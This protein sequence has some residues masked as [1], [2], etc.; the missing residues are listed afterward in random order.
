MEAGEVI[1]PGQPLGRLYDLSWLRA[2]VDVPDRYAPLIDTASPLVQRYIDLAMPGAVQDVTAAITI[3]GLPKLTGGTY[4]GIELPAEVH[5]VAH[6]ASPSS[7]TVRVELRLQ[8]PGGALKEGIIGQ[9]RITFLRY[10]RAIIIPLKAV[11][12]AEV[13][14]RV[15]VVEQSDGRWIARVRDIEPISI[16]DDEMLVRGGVTGGEHLVVSG[17]KGIVDGQEVL[18]VVADGHVVQAS[19][20]GAGDGPAASGR[21]NVSPGE[22]PR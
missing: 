4:A 17:A 3:P 5:R 18:V 22:A 7:N 13:G 14:P 11:Q 16:Q 2:A 21:N 1:S 10:G 9:A 6:A 19:T 12:V 15:L 20:P 8:N